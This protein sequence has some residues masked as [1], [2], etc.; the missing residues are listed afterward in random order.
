[1]KIYV[2]GPAS[3]RE[4]LQVYAAAFAQA[5]HEITSRWLDVPSGVGAVLDLSDSE[6]QRLVG[7]DLADVA[8]ADTLVM[9]VPNQDVLF[10]HTGGRH[11]EV[12]FALA[13]EIPVIVVGLPE[14]IFHRGAC[15]IVPDL[16][17]ALKVL[18]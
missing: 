2:A 17:A 13:L 3:A 10:G 9:F 4:E 8:I 14:N 12:G 6:V 15:V 18:A 5:G 16:D 7:R 1:M 11:V